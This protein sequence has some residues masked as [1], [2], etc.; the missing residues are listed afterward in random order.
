MKG[1]PCEKPESKLAKHIEKLEEEAELR[2]KSP[3]KK[4]RP[5]LRDGGERPEPGKAHNK[6]ID[7]LYT[8]VNKAFTYKAG[9]EDRPIYRFKA[10]GGN[11]TS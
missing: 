6:F 11:Y 2:K 7:N 8:N 10:L 5:E 3:P 4:V 1:E 9:E